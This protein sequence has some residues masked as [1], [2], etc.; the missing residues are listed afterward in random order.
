MRVLISEEISTDIAMK[1]KQA[2]GKRLEEMTKA[3]AYFR[4]S[5][6]ANVGPD[7]DSERRQRDAVQSFAKRAGF[8]IEDEFYDASISGAD[9]I[10]SR[11]GF[12][13]LLDRIESNGVRV[14]LVEDASRF[15]R[16]L[17]VQE[18]GILALV[19]RGV[20]VLTASGDD[21]TETD[22]PY[23]V[24]MRQ[25]AGV[26]SQLEKARLVLKLRAARERKKRETGRK[27][28]GRKRV[29][30]RK[31]GAEIVTEAKRLR[32]RSPKTGRRCSLREIAKQLAGQGYVSAS[33]RPFSSS[34]IKAMVES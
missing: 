22:D 29:A 28:E 32:R 10:E 33:G 9:P 20:R 5:S 27:V 6:A 31:D 12:M 24:A 30:E 4:T 2:K 14:V 18:A 15:A 21:L 11:P 8:V 19:D 23:K 7:K 1:A 17:V 16:Q 26:F 25:I 34:V 3:V 13:A